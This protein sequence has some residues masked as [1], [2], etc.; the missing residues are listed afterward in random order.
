MRTS[1]SASPRP[2]P[3]EARDE[4]TRDDDGRP[5]RARRRAAHQAARRDRRHGYVPP[6]LRQDPRQEGDH[7]PSSRSTSPTATRCP[8]SPTCSASRSR[9]Q[10]HVIAAAVKMMDKVGTASSSARWAPARRSSA[11]SP[12]TST[13]SGAG[14]KGGTDGKFRCI[15][16]CPDHLIA[17]WSR[18]IEETIPDAIVTRFGPQGRRGGE[19]ERPRKADRRDGAAQAGALGRPAAGHPTRAR[20]GHRW[21][22]PEGAEYYVLGRNQA[23]WCPDWVGLV[24]PQRGAS[25]ASVAS[26]RLVSSKSVVVDRVP[27]LDENDRPVYDKRTGEPMMENVTG[28]GPLLPDVRHGAPATSRG[29]PLAAKDLV[30]AKQGRQ[31]DRARYL[32][33]ARPIPD[34]RSSTAATGLALPTQARR[35]QARHTRSTTPAGSGS[36]RECKEPLCNCTSRPYRWAPARIIQQEDAADVRLPHDRR[37][38]RAEVRRVGAVDGVRQADRRRPTTSLALT[39]T[40]IGGYANHLYPLMMRITPDDAPRRGVRVGQG[41]RVLRDL[42]PDRPDRHHQ[43]GGPGP[44]RQARTSSRCGGPRAASRPSGRPSGPASCRRCSAGT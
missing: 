23:K 14:S 35:G 8:T 7:T 2:P 41:S 24:R 37:G 44:D 31:C 10:K 21:E 1:P 36:S 33:A 40:I 32:Q 20:H 42:R 3:S 12:S 18:E 16:L 5:R 9:C 13:P 19:S 11:W 22:K 15:V 34:R 26:S 6:E 29:V 43:G 28:P 39:G 38:A 4:R 27:M 17:K 30:E 25:T